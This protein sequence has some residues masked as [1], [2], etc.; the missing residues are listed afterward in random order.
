MRT[1]FRQKVPTAIR[2]GADLVS[3]PFFG[4]IPMIDRVAATGDTGI[5][6]RVL[7]EV[8]VGHVSG[9]QFLERRSG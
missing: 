8:L 7:A 4:R 2:K 6:T 9:V 5:E 1:Q 3:A